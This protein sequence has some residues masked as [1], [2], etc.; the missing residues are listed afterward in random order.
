MFAMNDQE[1]IICDSIFAYIIDTLKITIEP[2]IFAKST[3][4]SLGE[5][6]YN[7]IFQNINGATAELINAV[8]RTIRKNRDYKS[9][10]VYYRELVDVLGYKALPSEMIV[11]IRE[12]YNSIFVI[13]YNSVLEK[14]RVEMN[15]IH[16]ELAETKRKSDAIKAQKPIYSFMYDISDNERKLYELCAKCNSLRTRKEML[17][18]AF[19]HAKKIMREFCDLSDS[20]SVE[21]AI[22]NAAL[23][24]S[25][26]R[27]TDLRS[28][29]FLIYKKTLE[30][31]EDDIDR[32]YM[33]FYKVKIFII[34][35]KANKIFHKMSNEGSDDESIQ[36][37][38]DYLSRIPKIDD[39]FSLKKTDVKR[40]SE[41]LDLL[42]NDYDLLND[43]IQ[44]INESVCLRDRKT[45][46]LRS[47]EFF[48]QG[49][50]EIFNNIIPIQVEGL[51]LDYLLD[52]TTFDRFTNLKI[53]EDAVLKKKIELLGLAYGK[54]YFEATEY[55]MYY[56][57]N[58]IRNRIAHGKYKKN[59][60]AFYDEFFSKELF[61]DL[62]FLVY[63]ITRKSETEK[64]HR[65]VSDY[66]EYYEKC[67][68]SRANPLFEPLFNDITGRK[69]TV[70]YDEMESYRPVQVVYW[71]VNPYY[72]KIYEQVDDKS[73]LIYLREV[74]LG[75][76]FWGFVLEKLKDVK[77]KGYDYLMIN[78]EFASVIKGLF[79]CSISHET[80]EVLIEVNAIY[81]EIQSFK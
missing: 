10:D 20:S 6:Y 16:T 63:M 62:L 39:L 48:K 18:Y 33:L 37:Y 9:Q 71:L 67:L 65:F 26:E 19:S 47:I 66:R 34:I 80:K 53:Y 17:E 61:L 59:R 45:V 29:Y 70:D 12:E 5:F 72:E 36:Y 4:E 24:I 30:I 60:A 43:L 23:S 50:F 31:F 7:C 38:T 78:G 22:Q 27:N 3:F 11:S 49:E 14:Y 15:R 52:T 74:F 68:S 40:Y 76:D 57:N 42:I 13:E 21:L 55:F 41:K 8:V 58:I 79:K 51:F 2:E 81:R 54:P 46:L 44:L 73:K 64:M 56:F 77:R 35:E 1:K 69:L 32:E 75:K 28:T 25:R